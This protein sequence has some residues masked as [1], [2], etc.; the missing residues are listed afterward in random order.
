VHGCDFREVLRKVFGSDGENVRN[1]LV[2]NGI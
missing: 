2:E 1:V